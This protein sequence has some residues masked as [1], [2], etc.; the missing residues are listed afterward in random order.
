M[1][2]DACINGSGMN[3]LPCGLALGLAMLLGPRPASAQTAQRQDLPI[4]PAAKAVLDA[5][6]KPL[7][8]ILGSVAPGGGIAVGLGYDTP[9]SQDWFHN[10]SAKVT[11][12]GYWALEAETG[13]QTHQSRLGL[14]GAVRH[15]RDLDFFGVG[16]QSAR[17]DRSTYRLR[18][19]SF[20]T[21]GWVRVRP[22][23]RFGGIA[24]VY[25]PDLGSGSDPPRSIEH[26]FAADEVPGFAA[27]PLFTRYRGYVEFTHPTM[28]DPAS[29]GATYRGRQGTY[30]LAIEEVHDHDGGR[31]SF[32]RVE[33]EA[34]EQFSGVKPG[35]RLTLHGLIG[36]TT[37]SAVVPYYLQYTLGGNSLNAFRP[38]TIG[39]DG[40]RATLR[41]VPNY[42]FRDRDLL[43]MQAEYRIPLKKFVDATVF[44][45]AG[46]VAG[47][48][49]DLFKD[50]KQGAGFSVSYMRGGATVLRLDVG[51]G[52]GEGIHM[53][54]SFG[55]FG[56]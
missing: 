13:Y 18:E 9:R 32:H 6:E 20:G 29:P 40:T 43:V 48:V 50:I 15:M 21:R 34:R 2:H 37:G 51:H 39:S 44:Y 16:S 35:Q 42:R 1:W 5:F 31:F 41:S 8:P 28:A 45:D 52:G 36:A 19:S 47:R 27:D 53:F 11:F 24:Q 49:P 33:A 25:T 10:A 14:F 55:V 7:H 12:S 23:L 38:N 3:R 56:L 4:P 22:D 17:D 26:L 54:W 46:Q 30:Q